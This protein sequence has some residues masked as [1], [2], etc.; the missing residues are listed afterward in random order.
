[1]P[2]YQGRL[3]LTW[4]NKQLRLLAHED[5]S[6][7]WVS[8]SDYRVA[9][10]RLLHDVA[11]V[12]EAGQVRAADNLLI[13]GD[14]LNG[15]TSLSRLPE[16]ASEYLGKVKLVYIDP[17]FNTQ[18]SFLHYD[19]ALEH[20]VWLT[21]MRD[22]LLQIKEL[23]APEG[24]VWLHLDD[25]EVHH[26]RCVMDE[27]FG[28]NAFVATVLWQKRY[29][30]DNRP[31][32][33][34]V[35]DYI[36]VYAPLGEQWK[37]QR[38]RVVRLAAKEYRNPNNDPRGDWR[39]IPMTA[40]GW[41]PNQMYEITAPGGAVH[42]PPK[43]RC[44]SMVRERYDALLAEDRIYFGQDNNSQPNVI[45]YLDEDQGLVPWTWWPSDEVGHTDESKKEMLT[46]FPDHEAFDTPKPERLMQR[47]IQVASSP[48]EIV[49]DCFLGS[50]TT[51]AVAHKMG[52]R[53]VGIEREPATIETFT[54]PRLKKV[55]AGGDSGGISVVETLVGDDLPDGVKP[56]EARIAAKVLN[57]MSKSGALDE[58]DGL[59][60][61]TMKVLVALLRAADRTAIETV[62]EGGGGFR[63]L[64]VA[65]SM[66]E[67]D[68]G[69]VFLADWMANGVLAEATAAQLGFTYEADPPF[70]GRKGRTR[71]AVIDGVVN[72]SVIR[73]IVSALAK[74]ERVVVCGTGIDTDA[75]P[76][77]REL[78]P[79][80]TLRKIPAALLDE[81]RSARQLRLGFADP[82]PPKPPNAQNAPVEAKV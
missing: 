21:M 30:R 37:H 81:Y 77:L 33:G 26:A 36:L 63:V 71:L 16:F 9:E 69:L 20:S 42:T 82:E 22:R 11:T 29:S 12:G 23:L 25:S 18:Q 34:T 58:L 40:Q 47:I 50:G 13:R 56:G 45:R 60:G 4:T 62:W 1:M 53:W 24:S 73:L 80:S 66:F 61:D 59:D 70:S 31:A 35:H 5:G 68:G 28:P 67:T 48:G 79:G 6:Y 7:E 2:D 38:N 54:L 74:W 55:V 32:I 65:P 19:D 75:R 39:A 43:G 17:P 51:V 44:W 41:R 3:E 76:I 8:P 57:A 49:L 15:L 52:R 14:A 46:L 10:V 64:D 72:E 78:R 27:V